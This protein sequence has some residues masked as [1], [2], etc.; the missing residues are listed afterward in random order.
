M[1]ETLADRFAKALQESEAKNDPGPVAGLFAADAELSNLVHQE[2]GADGA[3]VFW[4]KYL[5]AFGSIRS[6][7][8][9]VKQADGWALL[10]WTSTGTLAAGKPV[11]YRGVSILELAGDKVA[12]FRTY[13]DTA[14]FVT[15]APV[16]SVTS[17]G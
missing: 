10:E 12:K 9:A 5:D 14:A 7:F 13:Y 15:P 1:P 8:S 17:D 11:E 3:R 4:R 2:R 6:E 16:S